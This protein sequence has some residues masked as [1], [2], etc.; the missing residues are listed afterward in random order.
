MFQQLLEIAFKIED[1]THQLNTSNL[2]NINHLTL[3]NSQLVKFLSLLKDIH[4]HN[5]TINLTQFFHAP[6][7]YTNPQSDCYQYLQ[8]IDN[9]FAEKRRRAQCQLSKT[10]K[11][12]NLNP[13]SESASN[14]DGCTLLAIMIEIYMNQA[15]VNYSFQIESKYPTLA[16]GPSLFP[17]NNLSNFLVRSQSTIKNELIDLMIDNTKQWLSIFN[18]LIGKCNCLLN[19][20]LFCG[21]IILYTKNITDM[22]HS[23]WDKSRPIGIARI[24]KYHSRNGKNSNFN[25]NNNKNVGLPQISDGLH[26]Q[27]SN[28][29]LS[30]LDSSDEH[31]HPVAAPSGQTQYSR[32]WMQNHYIPPIAAATGHGA[33]GGYSGGTSYNRAGGVG[34]SGLG[35]GLNTGNASESESVHGLDSDT[36]SLVG[37]SPRNMSRNVS[38]VSN[39]S[40]FSQ[41]N[42][43]N[44][45]NIVGINN[46]NDNVSVMVK[47]DCMSFD[48]DAHCSLFEYL[49]RDS[50]KYFF[51]KLLNDCVP[52]EMPE[53]IN[54]KL[55]KVYNEFIYNVYKA[56]CNA[57]GSI[58]QNLRC[59]YSIQAGIDINT[60][61]VDMDR[62]VSNQDVNIMSCDVYM[63]VLFEINKY[64]LDKE[65]NAQNQGGARKRYQEPRIVFTYFDPIL[66]FTP[67]FLYD[68]IFTGVVPIQISP[69]SKLF[70]SFL[71]FSVCCFFSVFFF[72]SV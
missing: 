57:T 44:H 62:S 24:N 53:Y 13:K 63:P 1:L 41:N 7:Q 70:V 66:S 3:I 48:F 4:Q 56:H 52:S 6:F 61:A 17:H 9:L 27:T 59:L 46:G 29:S 33:H 45:S 68:C 72:V 14:Y 40:T 5:P 11:N 8:R 49:F 34:G 25:F 26:P 35:L 51:M 18:F 37:L 38:N 64:V 50:K 60:I 19:Q 23:D 31:D 69:L 28:V 36:E 16:S 71:F 15:S 32:A 39:F 12:K 30:G 21:K 22:S 54:S 20:C 67:Q 47:A 55:N 2:E 42:N 10:T 65:E 43:I 58:Y